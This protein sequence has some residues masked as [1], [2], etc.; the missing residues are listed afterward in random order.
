MALSNAVN[1]QTAGVQCLT[2]AG[3]WNG[4]TITA[5]TGISVANGDGVSGNPTISATGS[6]LT[7]GIQNLGISLSGGTFSVTSA[8]GSALSASNPATVTLAS[9]ANPGR[10]VSVSVTADQTFI[11]DSG[12][13]TIIGNLFGLTTGIAF[14]QDIPFWIYAVLNDSENAV[15]FMISRYPAAKTSPASANIGKTGSAVADTQGSF[16]ALSNPTVTDYDANPCLNI[17]SIRMRMSASDDWTVQTLGNND[18]I[19]KFQFGTSFV[20]ATGQ[21]GAASGK[22]FKNNGG[23]APAFTT[24]DFNYYISDLSGFFD[25]YLDGN[26]VSTAG[27]G[28]VTLLLAL[29]YIIQGGDH[30]SGHSGLSGGLSNIIVPRL[31]TASTNSVKIGAGT[32]AKFFTNADIILNVDMSFF[33]HINMSSA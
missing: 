28:A 7:P 24:T 1:A 26:N 5:G 17:G 6:A 25:Y 3:V 9:K 13:S 23:T 18:G 21:F 30:G 19:G 4:R 33:G 29:P 22:F 32:A 16:F 27:V 31:A 11:D 8:D 14:A 20:M 2:S 10:L 15:S 12:S